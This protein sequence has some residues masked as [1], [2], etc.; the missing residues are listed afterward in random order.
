MSLQKADPT[1]IALQGE[2]TTAVQQK[3]AGEAT[4][5]GQR[6]RGLREGHNSSRPTNPAWMGE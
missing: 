2:I 6:H 4:Y 1:S 3:V 5:T